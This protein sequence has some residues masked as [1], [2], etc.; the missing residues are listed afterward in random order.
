MDKA[1]RWI[2]LAGGGFSLWTAVLSPPFSHLEGALSKWTSYQDD[3]RQFS[4][5]MDSVDASLNE[6]ER[7]SAE[8]REKTA[9]LGKAKVRAGFQI[10]VVV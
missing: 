3:V 10:A 4:N 8:L 2:G 1:D 6:S 9:A 5:W 7:P